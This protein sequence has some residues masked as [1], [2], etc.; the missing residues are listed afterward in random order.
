MALLFRILQI[1]AKFVALYHNL[2]E[3]NILDL[4]E[5]LY[6]TT[7]TVGTFD[8]VHLGHKAIFS[9]LKKRSQELNLNDLIITFRVHP[10]M[11]V[12]PSYK[13]KLLT[14]LNEK[15]QLI[16][17]QNI[18][19]LYILPFDKQMSEL[20]AED[21]V[22]KYLVEKFG[23]KHLIVGF[24]HRF[25]KNR[26][27]GYEELIPLGKKYGFSVEKVEPVIYSGEKISSS[28]IRKLI[29]EGNII[30]AN[31]LLGYKY[32][33]NGTVVKGRGIGRKIDFPTANIL[34]D[35]LKLMP[36]PGVYAVKVKIDAYEKLGVLN[37]GF[38]PTFGTSYG[39]VA[40]VHILN[41]SEQIYGK[42]IKITFLSRLRDE[43]KFKSPSE[44][45]KQIRLDIQKTV[46]LY[47]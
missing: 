46:E 38:R 31:N 36:K 4:H 37:Y 42:N 15:I 45:K 11:I 13:L 20:T 25:G 18:K 23:L 16:S 41:F 17:R 3:M 21:F 14:L 33:L 2:K 47:R 34:V 43:K 35:R 9:L 27:A 12:Q 5:K 7:I 30:E 28:R 24:D 10:R 40:E 1:T 19:H 29:T 8:G 44:L 6:N 22:R 32:F 26:Q 39:S